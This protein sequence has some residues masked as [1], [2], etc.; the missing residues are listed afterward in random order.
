M[1]TFIYRKKRLNDTHHLYLSLFRYVILPTLGRDK[2]MHIKTLLN[3]AENRN[4]ITCI[5]FINYKT[6]GY[7]ASIL[8]IG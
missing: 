8:Y 1:I 3:L 5:I 2:V 4:K 7:I 6:K